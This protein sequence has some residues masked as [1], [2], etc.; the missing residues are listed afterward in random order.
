[1]DGLAHTDIYTDRDKHTHTDADAHMDSL[2]YTNIYAD[3]NVD[4]YTD[5]DGH[6]YANLY[7]FSVAHCL[8][9]HQPDCV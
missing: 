9:Q 6:A 5:C 4:L 1:M 3:A 7:A 2:T 8:E